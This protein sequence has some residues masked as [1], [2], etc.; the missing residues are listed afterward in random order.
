MNLWYKF[1]TVLDWSFQKF[2]E[3]ILT[4]SYF[5]TLKLVLKLFLI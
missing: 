3:Q 5:K 1:L 2:L 4:Y